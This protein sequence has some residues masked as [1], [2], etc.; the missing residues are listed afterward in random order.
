MREKVTYSIHPDFDVDMEN[1]SKG[2]VGVNAGRADPLLFSLQ[3]TGT[4]YVVMPVKRN[5]QVAKRSY[6]NAYHRAE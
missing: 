2:A 3:S 4:L 6:A 5:G 1:L